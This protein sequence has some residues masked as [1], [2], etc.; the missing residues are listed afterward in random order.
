MIYFSLHHIWSKL[1]ASISSNKTKQVS[2]SFNDEFKIEECEY[3]NINLSTELNGV[4]K[5]RGLYKNN[6]TFNVTKM[7]RENDTVIGYIER[8][9]GLQSSEYT[10]PLT[11]FKAFFRKIDVET[12]DE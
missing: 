8:P 2:L 5:Q 7:D 6:P 4:Y 12:D 1:M 10:L 3:K 11:V 9:D